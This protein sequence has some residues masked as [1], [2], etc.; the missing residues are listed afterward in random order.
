MAEERV[1]ISREAMLQTKQLA[2]DASEA[3]QAVKDAVNSRRKTSLLT[4]DTLT[5][6]Q[7][8][9]ESELQCLQQEIVKA[10]TSV[11]NQAVV[12]WNEQDAYTV[13][14]PA[15]NLSFP[16]GPHEPAAARAQD[17]SRSFT[18]SSCISSQGCDMSAAW[19]RTA[20]PAFRCVM[21]EAPI[22]NKQYH[23]SP[24]SGLSSGF[25]SIIHTFGDVVPLEPAIQLAIRKRAVKTIHAWME[26]CTNSKNLSRIAEQHHC[27]LLLRRVLRYWNN[28]VSLIHKLRSEHVSLMMRRRAESVMARAFMMWQTMVI[29][30]KEMLHRFL[31]V[32]C[33]HAR[34]LQLTAMQR[35]SDHALENRRKRGLIQIARGRAAGRIL[36]MWLALVFEAQDMRAK[37][38]VVFV[39][40][41][42][43][44][45]RRLLQTWLAVI[46]AKRQQRRALIEVA[47]K[48]RS[49]QMGTA[50][51][52]W[53]ARCADKALL[54]RVFSRA[55]YYWDVAI[56]VCSMCWTE[57]HHLSFC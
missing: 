36:R 22:R 28:S 21:E 30:E 33:A 48:C 25:D 41:T 42:H 57:K 53:K 51:Q 15:P 10:P 5:S 43:R 13:A 2:A 46:V 40:C 54:S 17:I 29:R 34:R 4:L 9:L 8:R 37:A 35:L 39:K 45:L 7:Q 38:L 14:Y 16:T 11:V 24:R 44:H 47:E 19:R 49:R 55:K 32:R 56:R 6:K 50:V 1:S 52:I 23:S 26:A 31:T 3:A 20:L 12:I 18:D 27:M